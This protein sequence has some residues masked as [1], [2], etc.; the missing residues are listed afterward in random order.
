MTIFNLSL[1]FSQSGKKLKI[2]IR[3][4]KIMAYF[5]SKP[6]PIS[7]MVNQFCPKKLKEEITIPAKT[8][9]SFHLLVETFKELVIYIKEPVANQRMKKVHN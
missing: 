6:N 8:T 3:K 2:K 9:R 1:K 5:S 4:I 7:L